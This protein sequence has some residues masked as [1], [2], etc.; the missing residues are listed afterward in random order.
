MRDIRFYRIDRSLKSQPW[1]W[2][3]IGATFWPKKQARRTWSQ[4]RTVGSH[5]MLEKW[6]P[7]PSVFFMLFPDLS[8][9]RPCEWAQLF[10]C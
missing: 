4:G 10:L 7:C 9:R 8:S 2:V 1:K 5:R 6:D 3:Q